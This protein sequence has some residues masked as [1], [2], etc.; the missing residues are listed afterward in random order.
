MMRRVLSYCVCG[1]GVNISILL[2]L[3]YLLTSIYLLT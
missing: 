2:L 1:G 3:T